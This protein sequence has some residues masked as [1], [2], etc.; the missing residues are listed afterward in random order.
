MAKA[1]IGHLSSDQRPTGALTAENARLRARIRDLEELVRQL[2]QDNEALRA[3]PRATVR[4]DREPAVA[5][6]MQPV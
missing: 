6:A 3:R 5:G 4:H 1:L 2:S